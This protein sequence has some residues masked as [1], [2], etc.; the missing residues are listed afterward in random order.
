MWYMC[1]GGRGIP[2]PVLTP[3]SFE[4]ATEKKADQKIDSF[5]QFS[6]KWRVFFADVATFPD[7]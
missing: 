1:T 6:Q 5:G 3:P 2:K 4:S 7:I